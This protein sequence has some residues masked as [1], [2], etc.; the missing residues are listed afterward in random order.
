MQRLSIAA[1]VLF[2]NGCASAI[3]FNPQAGMSF[4]EWKTTA[5]RSLRGLPELVGM[6]GNIAVYYLPHSTEK[7]TFYWFENGR[8]TQVT[9]GQLPKFDTKSRPSIAKAPTP[10][11]LERGGTL[12]LLFAAARTLFGCPTTMSA[13]CGRR[14]YCDIAQ[15]LIPLSHFRRINK[16]PF[17]STPFRRCESARKSG[18]YVDGIREG[19]LVHPR[20]W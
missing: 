17:L 15:P 20:S 9:Q 6:R 2:L 8:L 11:A 4:D 12:A 18:L 7:N 16:R 14:N 1:L 19:L 3:S 10:R 13:T 5:A